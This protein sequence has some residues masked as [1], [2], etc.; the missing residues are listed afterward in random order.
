MITD[1]ACLRELWALSGH[2]MADDVELM[3]VMPFYRLNWP[4]GTNFDYSND[5]EALRRRNRRISP[6][7]RRRL[8]RV[9]ALF[10]RRLTEGYVKLGHVPFLDFTSMIKAAP[11]LTKLSGLALGLFDRVELHR[12]P[13]SCAR[14]SASTRCW[15]AATR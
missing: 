3:P 15:W 7:G 2:D 11:A 13:R 8:R 14:P 1:P 10:R 4:D 9:P 6:G 12:V 5:E